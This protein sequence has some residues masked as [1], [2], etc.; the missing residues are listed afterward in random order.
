MRPAQQVRASTRIVS[1]PS[2]SHAS[3]APP[4]SPL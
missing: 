2:N 3:G 1:E 4:R